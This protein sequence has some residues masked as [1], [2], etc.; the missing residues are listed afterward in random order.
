MPRD[1]DSSNLRLLEA[2][3]AIAWSASAETFAFTYVSQFAEKLLGYPAQN[4]IDDPTFWISH[5]H[6][7]DQYVAK[8]CHDSTLACRNHELVYRMIA[9]DGRSVYLRDYVNVHTV[10]GVPVELFGVMVDITHERQLEAEARLSDLGQLAASLA[11]EFNN[12]LMSIQPFVEVI[13]RGETTPSVESALDHITRAISR[14]KRASQ[15]V[16]R[17]ASP[18]DPQLSSVEVATWLA[19][20]L[21]ELEAILPSTMRLTSSIAP[22][23]GWI[24][25]DR[26]QLEQVLTNLVINARDAV[27]PRGNILVTANREGHFVRL[28]VLDD[29][30]GI[31]QPL[32]GRIFEPLVTTKR[33][34]TGLGLP[35]ARRLMESQGGSLRVENLA[36]GGAAFHVLIPVAS[37]SPSLPYQGPAARCALKR[38]L[39]VEDDASVGAGIELLLGLEGFETVWVRSFAEACEVAGRTSPELAIVDIDLPDG[40]GIDLASRLRVGNPRLAIILSTGHVDPVAAEG[41]GFVSLLKPYKVEDLLEAIERAVEAGAMKAT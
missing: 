16:L 9:A 39:L 36:G 28:S 25:C 1:E 19:T 37:E 24:A 35:I 15:E 27:N 7:E 22:D 38:V 10:D 11:H 2:I 30:C 40:N 3:P 29:G 23:L 32:L 5:L 14:G 6:P 34:G 4:W 18:K 20:V 33:H 12:V 8:V 26:A 21:T 17:F 41:F 31:P 13:H